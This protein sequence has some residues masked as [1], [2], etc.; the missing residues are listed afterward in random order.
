MI[1]RVV[2][3][4]RGQAVTLAC[5]R[6]SEPVVGVRDR[7]SLAVAVTDR[8]QIAARGV[9]VGADDAARPG[10]RRQAP[11]RH[12]IRTIIVCVALVA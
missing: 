6:T 10:A 3:K 7:R 11:R 9:A 1:D 2:G 8:H 5:G 12:V 4:C